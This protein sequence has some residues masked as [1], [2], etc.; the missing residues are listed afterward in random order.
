MKN[1]FDNRSLGFWVSLLTA[2][3]ALIGAIL[4]LVLDGADAERTFSLIGFIIVLVGVV[5]ELLVVM[6]R[7]KF[8]AM[9]PTFC[10]IAGFSIVLRCTV[11]SVSDVLNGVNFIGGNATM[12]VIFSVVFFVCSVLGCVSCFLG[13]V[14]EEVE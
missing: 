7:L 3:L 10:Y 1:W 4:Y 14:K 2:A 13:Q 11:P 8:A 12:G 6:T 5:S 9:I